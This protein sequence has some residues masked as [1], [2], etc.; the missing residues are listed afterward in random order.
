MGIEPMT[1]GATILYSTNWATISIVVGEEGLAPPEA[2]T[3]AFTE[4]P[5]TNYG[6]H[7]HYMSGWYDSNVRSPLQHAPVPKTGEVY[8]LLHI[9]IIIFTDLSMILKSKKSFINIEEAL[10]KLYSLVTFNI[11]FPKN[12]F[13]HNPNIQKTRRKMVV[14]KGAN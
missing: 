11:T 12:L 2:L 6:I 14:H 3:T 1:K 10:Y 13:H 9:Q 5:A 8:Q 4:L 7:S